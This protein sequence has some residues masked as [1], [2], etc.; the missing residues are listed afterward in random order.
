MRPPV[1][2]PLLRQESVSL[3]IMNETVVTVIPELGLER[4]DILTIP[5]HVGTTLLKDLHRIMERGTPKPWDISW[6]SKLC[7]VYSY[8]TVRDTKWRNKRLFNYLC[9]V[10]EIRGPFH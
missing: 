5:T 6:Y 8:L 2:A 10:I 9:R 4:Q 1:P 7:S 3:E